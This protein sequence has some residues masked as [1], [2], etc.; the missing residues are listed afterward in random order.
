M[1][2]EENTTRKREHKIKATTE[3]TKVDCQIDDCT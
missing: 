3:V 2:I 1:A